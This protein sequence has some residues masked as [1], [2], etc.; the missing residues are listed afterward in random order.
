M[1]SQQHLQILLRIFHYFP[2]RLVENKQ[3]ICEDTG[4]TAVKHEFQRCRNYDTKH[5]IKQELQ[6]PI[7]KK[8]I[9]NEIINNNG[10]SNVQKKFTILH[11][12]L[13]EQ[14]GNADRYK[15]LLPKA[16]HNCQSQWINK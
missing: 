4:R 8:F 2:Y 5:L 11:F 12:S 13:V 14:Y 9:N 15:M 16:F 1:N 6:V 7:N 10:E 3:Q